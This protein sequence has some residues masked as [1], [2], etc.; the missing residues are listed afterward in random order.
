MRE[1][2]TNEQVE[3]IIMTEGKNV[4][5]F[6]LNIVWKALVVKLKVTIY[7]LDTAVFQF[8]VPRQNGMDYLIHERVMGPAFNQLI[9]TSN[10]NITFR[11]FELEENSQP[12]PKLDNFRER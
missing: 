11:R 10:L 8:T 2:F 6:K 4:T 3:D 5:N 7:M 12:N 9:G 1:F